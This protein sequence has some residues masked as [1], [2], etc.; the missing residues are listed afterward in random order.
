MQPRRRFEQIIRPALL[1]WRRDRK[2]DGLGRLGAGRVVVKGDARI[3]LDI[4][5]ELRPG[6]E[7]QTGP[8]IARRR[9][10]VANE[11][12]GHEPGWRPRASI[13]GTRREERSTMQR[14]WR[15]VPLRLNGR[16]VRF[17]PTADNHELGDPT[18][19]PRLYVCGQPR[20]CEE[21]RMRHGSSGI[22]LWHAILGDKDR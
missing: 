22:N 14:W 1:S 21:F 2:Q 8:G 12:D 18:E 16:T 15:T 6:I 13:E 19:L 5:N 3:F 4:G 11:G 7:H 9:D 20:L 17:V 10:R